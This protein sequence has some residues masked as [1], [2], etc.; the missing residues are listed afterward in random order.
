MP[1]P[2]PDDTPAAGPQERPGTPGG[3]ND[4]YLDEQEYESF[5]A[6]DPHSDWAGPPTS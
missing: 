6:S 1:D 4:D 3:Q 2:R 5:P